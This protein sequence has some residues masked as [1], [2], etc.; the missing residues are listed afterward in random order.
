ATSVSGEFIYRL[1]NPYFDPVG[2]ALYAE[3]SIGNGSRSFEVKALIQKNYLNDALRTVLNVNVEDRWEKDAL[4]RY[5]QSS[6]L[7]FFAGASYN[8]TPEWSA[9]VEL[10]HERDFDGLI[11]GGSWRGVDNATFFGP[12]IQYVG[13]PLHVVFGAQAQLPWAGGD[14]SALQNGYLA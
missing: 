1:M 4:G 10:A 13:H 11:L 12:T 3:P 5:E 2:L 14:R 8:L 6:A 9:G 7:E